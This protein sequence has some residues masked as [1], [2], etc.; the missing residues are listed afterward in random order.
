MHKSGSPVPLIL[1]FLSVLATPFIVLQSSLALFLVTL[2]VDPHWSARRP[3]PPWD[4]M[5]AVVL[6]VLV[7]GAFLLVLTAPSRLFGMGWAFTWAA[8]VLVVIGVWVAYLVGSIAGFYLFEIAQ[9]PAQRS[10]RVAY[11]LSFWAGAGIVMSAIL[12]AP[13]AASPTTSRFRRVQ[14]VYIAIVGVFALYGVVPQIVLL[15]VFG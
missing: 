10:A 11:D 5:I 6:A 3:G 14:F 7:A 2:G 9:P 4:V 12:L 1:F 15:A 13:L 8:I